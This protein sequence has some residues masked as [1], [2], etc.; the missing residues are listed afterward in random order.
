MRFIRYAYCLAAAALVATSPV[1]AQ[2]VPQSREQIQLTFSPVVKRVAPSVVNIYTARRVQVRSPFSPLMQDPFFEQF[3]GR[4]FGGLQRERVVNSLGSGVIID[5]KGT[6]VTSNHVVEG[7]EDIVIA[8]AD[9]RELKAKIAVQDP[10]SDLALIKLTDSTQALPALPIGDSDA[11]QVGDLVLAVGNP[12]GVGQTVTSGIV[13]ALARSAEGVSDY[14]FFIQTD[15]AIN[16]GNSGGAL[17][18]MNG[19]L[20]GI[21][22][23][24]YSQTGGS[25]GIGFAIPSSMITALMSN[26]QQGGAVLRPWLG[27]TYQA[28]SPEI[29]NSLGMEAP[30]GALIKQVTSGSPAAEAGLKSG[31]VV[32]A[33]NGVAIDSPNAL[34]FRIATAKIDNPGSLSVLR[35]G[36]PVDVSAALKLPPETPAR[37]QRTLKGQHPLNGITVVNISPRVADEFN[38]ASDKTGVLIVNGRGSRFGF[39]AGDIILSVNR[40]AIAST[41]QLDELMKKPF[42]GWNIDFERGGQKLTLQVVR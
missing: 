23:A 14:S 4:S 19:E 22:T 30:R 24:I 29:A 7:A 28:V 39:N 9:G 11:M 2:P 32:T 26:T 31:D 27:A 40:T 15:A 21:N 18:N 3:L 5:A 33:V 6:I 10:S 41:K 34:R 1:M 37:D 42:G 35:D 13:S 25:L 36:K 38:L 16:P 17:V 20:I 12:F 8:L